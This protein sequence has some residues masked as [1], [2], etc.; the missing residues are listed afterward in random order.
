MKNLKILTG[1]ICLSLMGI[2][3]AETVSANSEIS[4]EVIASCTITATNMTFGTF[5][6]N[7]SSTYPTS[8]GIGYG[9]VGGGIISPKC[10]KGTS[11]SISDNRGLNGDS[12][13]KYGYM[14]HENDP[15]VKIAYDLQAIGDNTS[16]DITIVTT[17]P[18]ANQIYATGTGMGMD[19]NSTISFRVRIRSTGSVGSMPTF[20]R[21][22]AGN[23]SDIV[24]VTVTY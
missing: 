20:R 10:T 16:N 6:P 15:N 22:I 2:S 24:T 13:I 18:N 8:M 17:I 21:A 14:N 1:L 12:A 5:S 9:G 19:Y 23:Y 3:K 11:Y 7:D 4:T